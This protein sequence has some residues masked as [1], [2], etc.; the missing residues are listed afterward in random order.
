MTR[1]QVKAV[2]D[3]VLGWCRERQQDAVHALS[4]MAE[5]ERS[6]LPL[7]GEDAAELRRRLA[8]PSDFRIPAERVFDRFRT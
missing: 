1:D 2:V 4:K 3:R 7:S 6:A 8:N 5:R